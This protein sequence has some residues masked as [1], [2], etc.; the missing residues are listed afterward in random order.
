MCI[1][2]KYLYVYTF[3]DEKNQRHIDI[4]KVIE[5]ESVNSQNELLEILVSKGHNIT[6]A[7]LSRD[8]KQLKASKV[9][10]ENGG[11]KYVINKS[12]IDKRKSQA[13][14]GYTMSGFLS[15]EFSANLG[16]IKTKPAFSGPIAAA[17]DS[18]NADEILG[19]I[20]GDDTI[21]LIVREG[22]TKKDV[23]LFLKRKFPILNEVI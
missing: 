21:M 13:F 19:T 7:T 4:K 12:E 9:P 15:L 1:F 11:Y 3:M 16:I 20:A 2:A 6:Q 14:D 18:L 5:G 23:I 17:I 8:L 22:F 10:N